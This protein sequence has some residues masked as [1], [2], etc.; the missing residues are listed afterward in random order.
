MRR[1][2]FFSKDD[3]ASY[4]M[5]NQIDEFFKNKSY[6]SSETTI[7]DLLEKQHI[8]LYMDNDFVHDTWTNEEIIDYKKLTKTFKEEI[9]LYFRSLT[10]EK[11]SAFYNKIRFDYYSTF[12]LLLNKTGVYKMFSNEDLTELLKNNR[13][14]LRDVLYCKNIVTH[15]DSEISSHI[16]QNSK[17][18]EILLDYYEAHH[19]RVPKEMFFPKSLTLDKREAIICNYLDNEDANLN[20]VRLI[21]SSKDSD[22]LKFSDKIKFKAKRISKKL[23]DDIRDSDYSINIRKGV[24]LSEDQEEIKKVIFKN[25][26]KI[27]SYSKK[28]LLENSDRII[29]FKNFKTVF[30]LLDKQGGINLL[31]RKREIDTFESAI[32]I[33]SKN[34]YF[35]SHSFYEKRMNSLLSFEVYKIALDTINIS[36]ENLIENYV[37]N[38][39]NQTFNINYFKLHLPSSTSTY[40]EKIRLIV[41]EFESV[42]E[43]YKLYVEDDIIDYELLQVSTKTSK[44]NTIPSILENKYIYP[45]GEEYNKL[46]HIFFSTN[47]YLFNYEKHKD[48]YQSLFHLLVD[49]NYALTRDDFNTTQNEYLQHF[50]D[51]NYIRESKKGNIE[52]IDLEFFYILFLFSTYDVISYWHLP[53]SI[54]KKIILLDTKGMV[55]FSNK[56]LT[57]AEQEY[58]DFYLNNRFSNGLWLRNKY[59]HATNSHD[60]EIQK[61][62]YRTLL[63]LMVLLILKIEDDLSLACKILKENTLNIMDK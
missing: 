42:L 39:L 53:I 12:W 34:D 13:T 22:H 41:P 27:I 14:S 60:E 1:I 55:K 7:N 5:L 51:S 50:I 46:I 9:S 30:E 20:Y 17:N 11:I 19:D 37:N 63:V 38:Y 18:A 16:I 25:N 52:I 40:L 26:V 6:Q 62:D 10:T 15:F 4:S 32:G 28:R 49:P 21:K 24:S 59:V 35:L 61:D 54:R 45:K 23:N 33:N 58:F 47:S 57:T 44:F 3:L 8:I 31:A 43:Q 48:K 56:L 29:L 2:I 36:F